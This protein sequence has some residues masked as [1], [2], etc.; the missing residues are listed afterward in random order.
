MDAEVNNHSLSSM[1]PAH[2][3]LPTPPT[4]APSPHPLVSGE[5]CRNARLRGNPDNQRHHSV[6]TALNIS[7]IW[8]PFSPAV[9]FSP[10]PAPRAHPPPQP[11]TSMQWPF[12]GPQEHSRK[13]ESCSCG[14]LGQG[15]PS[16]V[17]SKWW[18]WN[19]RLLRQQRIKEPKS[20]CT[21]L[22]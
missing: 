5:D 7:Q 11:R 12:P 18:L 3:P 9:A 2:V 1:R 4:L 10:C 8:F 20:P 6:A 14:S 17:C 22:S 16:E 21:P 15:S 19:T 13:H